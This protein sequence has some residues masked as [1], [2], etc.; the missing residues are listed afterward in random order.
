MSAAASVAPLAACHAPGAATGPERRVRPR[1]GLLEPDS[2]PSRPTG[3]SQIA[4]DGPEAA[5]TAPLA[6]EPT[7]GPGNAAK[8]STAPLRPV[9]RASRSKRAVPVVAPRELEVLSLFAD[10]L[11]LAQIAKQLEL[12]ESEVRDV[13]ASLV[14][15][16]GAEL[17]APLVAAGFAA[18]LLTRAGGVMPVLMLDDRRVLA[19]VAA[20]WSDAR[21][22]A[23]LGVSANAAH[24]RVDRLRRRFLVGGRVA[25]TRRAFDVGLLPASVDLGGAR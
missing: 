3:P 22:G 9:S 1:D 8:R 21:M 2:G 24:K 20:G 11:S 19:M 5:L 14:V 25:L 23:A 15:T 4:P 13:F 10:G 7:T 12:E 6:P 18:R 17:G 16:L